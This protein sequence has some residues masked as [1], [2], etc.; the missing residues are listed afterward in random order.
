MSKTGFP[1]VR[2]VALLGVITDTEEAT[3]SK[4]VRGRAMNSKGSIEGHDILK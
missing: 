1:N 2:Q 4:G 3:S